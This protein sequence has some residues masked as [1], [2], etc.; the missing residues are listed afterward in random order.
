MSHTYTLKIGDKTLCFAFKDEDPDSFRNPAKTYEAVIPCGVRGYALT[1]GMGLAQEVEIA[2]GGLYAFD[3]SVSPETIK[4]RAAHAA[5]LLEAGLVD[6]SAF[7]IG[8][9]IRDRQVFAV[10]QKYFSVSDT[11][12]KY[13]HLATSGVGPCAALILTAPE[14]D[15]APATALIAH[16]DR[17]TDIKPSMDFMVTRFHPSQSVRAV[18]MGGNTHLV[19]ACH[20][21]EDLQKR[22]IP[23][24]THIGLHSS[25]AVEVQTGKVIA[26]PELPMSAERTAVVN[27]ADLMMIALNGKEQVRIGVDDRSVKDRRQAV[28]LRGEEIKGL[29]I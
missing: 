11:G 25:V 5:G 8:T 13:T 6:E 23:A 19:L 22:G 7:E 20:L 24:Q 12:G 29:V 15:Y 21:V 26:S 18:I 28:S 10:E 16:L 4:E 27:I 1:S 17:Q 3:N 2:F 9:D 14:N